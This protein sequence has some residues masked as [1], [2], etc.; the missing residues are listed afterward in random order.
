M[1]KATRMLC[2]VAGLLIVPG[3]IA[4]QSVS[5]GVLGGF[6][7]VN[8]TGS[9]VSSGW[10]PAVRAGGTVMVALGPKLELAGEV[11]LAHRGEHVL[12]VEQVPGTV[13]G[14]PV[15]I[16]TRYS[17]NLR[18]VAVPIL[19]SAVLPV[20]P[21]GRI[22][23]RLGGGASVGYRVQ[24]VAETRVRTLYPGGATRS[25]S[26]TEDA[27]D[28]TVRT[29]DVGLVANGG[30]RF[31]LPWGDMFSDARYQFGLASAVAGTSGRFQEII[32]S[33]GVAFGL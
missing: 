29:V 27:C 26:S 3:A 22:T 2:V 11:V 23:A 32:V 13:G 30:L 6:N 18:H 4:A 12:T 14:E 10:V 25:I 17:V 28:D 15:T 1:V 7:F 20:T 9:S 21:D 19:V 16:E 31:R 5:A 8:Y 24:C 33:V